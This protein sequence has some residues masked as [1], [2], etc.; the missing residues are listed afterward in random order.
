MYLKKESMVFCQDLY[1]QKQNKFLGFFLHVC[2][3]KLESL[4]KK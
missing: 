3:A 1:E 4:Y 2:I